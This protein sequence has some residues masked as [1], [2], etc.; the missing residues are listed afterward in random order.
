MTIGVCRS[1]GRQRLGTQGQLL[2]WIILPIA[3]TFPAYEHENLTISMSFAI[4]QE[5]DIERERELIRRF[6]GQPGCPMDDA[7][8]FNRYLKQER[9]QMEALRTL[10]VYDGRPAV[11]VTQNWYAFLKS[12]HHN[13]CFRTEKLFLLGGQIGEIAYAFQQRQDRRIFWELTPRPR[14]QIPNRASVAS[15]PKTA[16]VSEAELKRV[17]K[18]CLT[19]CNAR[20]LPVI[21]A[22]KKYDA[23]GREA[24]RAGVLAEKAR[25]LRATVEQ[26]YLELRHGQVRARRELENVKPL[27][28]LEKEAEKVEKKVKRAVNEDYALDKHSRE[29]RRERDLAK[30]RAF[31]YHDNFIATIGHDDKPQHVYSQHNLELSSPLENILFIVSST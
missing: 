13:T 16:H 1:L 8:V 27:K 23:R 12:C 31:D 25:E 21:R 14:G 5:E 22:W 4:K 11:H 26:E 10:Y 28:T 24:W 6:I 17:I 19:N 29:A 3:N 9:N 15:W 18:S 30:N 2:Q 7:V 20:G